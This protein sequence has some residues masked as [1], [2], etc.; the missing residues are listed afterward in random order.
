VKLKSRLEK[1][2]IK[3]EIIFKLG[4]KL[5]MESTPENKNEYKALEVIG[6]SWQ[7][8]KSKP[9]LFLPQIILWGIQYT[10]L[11]LFITSLVPILA[12]Q[13][14]LP[15]EGLPSWFWGGLLGWLIVTIVATAW[16]DGSYPLL[17][18]D[19]VEG[20]PP[21]ITEAFKGAWHRLPSLLGATVLIG[22]IYIGCS[23]L[24]IV[25]IAL[26]FFCMVWFYHYAPAIMLDNNRTTVSLGT[27]KAFSLGKKWSIFGIILFIGLVPGI[28]ALGLSYIPYL[29][30]VLGF[31]VSL[32]FTTLGAIIPAYGYLKHKQPIGEE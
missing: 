18:K 2:G 4:G 26:I 10:G 16:I 21:K 31:V 28:I 6:K 22:L 29:G 1:K 24:P 19:V 17:I 14:Y 27:S 30:R 8:L 11:I 5:K 15:E 13:S 3:R 20:K 9:I 25:G 7:I 12:G 32:L 23:F